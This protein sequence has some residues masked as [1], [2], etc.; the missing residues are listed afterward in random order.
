LRFGLAL[1][2][3]VLALLRGFVLGVLWVFHLGPVF[4]IAVVFALALAASFLLRSR[5]G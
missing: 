2:R 3:Q 5:K 1:G 4:A